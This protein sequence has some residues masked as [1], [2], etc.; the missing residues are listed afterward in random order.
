MS[1]DPPASSIFPRTDWA[2]LAK[3]NEDEGTRLDRLIRMYWEP[4]KIFFVATFPTLRDHADTYL[5][6]FAEDKMLKQGWLQQADKSRGKFR[7]FLKT[8]LRHFTLDRLNRAEVKHAPMSLDELEVDLPGPDAP[9]EQ[10]DLS[11]AQTVLGEALRRMEAD[12]RN[13]AAEQPRRT[14][15]W[16]MFRV[17]LL[18]PLFN[19]APQVP[20]EQ[21]IEKF[22]LR[23]PMDAS[24]LLLSGKRIFKGHLGQVIEDY[25]GKDTATA[26]EIAALEEFL[27]GLAKRG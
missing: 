27:A 18:E 9:S 5:Q 17:R 24:N 6:E 22:Q 7:N 13:P 19:D 25:A 14:Y 23:S 1:S 3:V 16:E 20:Y 8:S 11:W 15:I 10:F 26:A 4:L 2:E 21:L 12:C